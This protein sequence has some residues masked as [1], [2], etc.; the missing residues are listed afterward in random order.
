MIDGKN[1][2]IPGKVIVGD[3]SDRI[4]VMGWMDR[5]INIRRNLIV[6]YTILDMRGLETAP[7][8]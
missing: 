7:S 6:R 1:R 4:I 2:R 5:Q 8:L 3:V